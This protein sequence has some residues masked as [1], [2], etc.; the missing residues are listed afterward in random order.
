MARLKTDAGDDENAARIMAAV[1]RRN[2]RLP[3]VAEH[4]TIAY[5][6]VDLTTSRGQPST[7]RHR[8]LWK[9]ALLVMQ[10]DAAER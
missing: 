10:E 7:A 3:G 2:S 9:S 5:V 4:T 1:E 6:I 8:D